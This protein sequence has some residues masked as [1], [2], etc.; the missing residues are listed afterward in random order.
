M[1]ETALEHQN[2]LDSWQAPDG[3]SVYEVVGTGVATINGL[4]YREF[5]CDINPSCILEPFLKPVPRFVLTGDGTVVASSA[6][7]YQKNK[8]NYLVNLKDESLLFS[9]NHAN[10]TESDAVINF[11]ESAVL[12][13]YLADS[14]V[15]E[16]FATISETY[17]IIGVHSPVS[18][19][20]KNSNG[21]QVGKINGEIKEDINN[22]SYFELAGSKYVIIPQNEEI[23]VVLSGESTG[24][25]SLTIEKVTPD[26]KQILL[27]EMIGATST[28]EL[29]AKFMCQLGSCG[30][31]AVDYDGDGS[32]DSQFDWSGT[33]KSLRKSEIPEH[34]LISGGSTGTRVQKLYGPDGRVAGVS[35][36]IAQNDLLK[37]WNQLL[38]IERVLEQI[39]LSFKVNIENGNQI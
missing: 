14:L 20:V 23:N 31:I 22:S 10:I 18:I 11:I 36:N 16:E 7:A 9:K 12:Y 21:Q 6:S 5:N 24:R 19:I 37:M 30:V 1:L 2:V 35:T 26:G 39:E 33:Y 34:L 15:I 29:S 13:P 32:I 4:H 8:I 27:Q 17:L 25:Y 38:E 3:V 28:T